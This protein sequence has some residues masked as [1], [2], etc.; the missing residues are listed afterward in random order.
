MILHDVISLARSFALLFCHFWHVLFILRALDESSPLAIP[1]S[2]SLSTHFHSSYT[3]FCCCLF[4]SFPLR[5]TFK[6]FPR[7]WLYELKFSWLLLLN[8]YNWRRQRRRWW[9]QK[10]KEEEMKNNY[11]RRQQQLNNKVG[12][13][14]INSLC[15]LLYTLFV[16]SF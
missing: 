11:Q 4:L 6:A 13:K 15:N 1:L 10:S 16:C 9:W 5:W 14:R 7:F 12:F 2:R 3:M 8:T